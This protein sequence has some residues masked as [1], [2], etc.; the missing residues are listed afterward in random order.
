MRVTELPSPGQLSMGTA[1]R[2]EAAKAISAVQMMNARA[3]GATEVA[4]KADKLAD[5]FEACAA[6]VRALVA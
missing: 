5:F 1:L 6:S 4:A 3:P 2:T